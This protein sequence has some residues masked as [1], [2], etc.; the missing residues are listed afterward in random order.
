MQIDPLLF[1]SIAFLALIG[2]SIWIIRGQ[3]RIIDR[4]MTA[5]Y[6]EYKPK[7]I[8]EED[9]SPREEDEPKTWYDH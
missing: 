2:Y 8:V 3:Q 9:A 7:A 1:I 6:G 5:R 4:L